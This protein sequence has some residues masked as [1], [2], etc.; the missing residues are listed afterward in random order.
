MLDRFTEEIVSEWP[1]GNDTFESKA[2]CCCF[3]VPDED[4]NESARTCDLTQNEHWCIARDINLN[5]DD[6]HLDHRFTL[7]AWN[8]NRTR[9]SGLAQILTQ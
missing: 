7:P 1:R 9:G 5:V 2:D 4:R 3:G 6:F 8:S